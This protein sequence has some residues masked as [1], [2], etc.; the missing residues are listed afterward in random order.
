M[1][2]FECGATALGIILA[3]YGR[4]LPMSVLRE[5]C[6]VSTRGV[7]AAGML[8]AAR[9]YGLYAQGYRVATSSQLVGVA[10]PFISYWNVNHF[11]VVEGFTKTTI[12]LNDPAQGKRRVT[13][14][15]FDQEMSGVVLTFAPS[16]TFQRGGSPPTLWHTLFAH[17]REFGGMSI[18]V[19]M[20]ILCLAGAAL[21]VPLVV[22]H[23][24]DNGAN[25]A[26]WLLVGI[27]LL[28][29]VLVWGQQHLLA[30][31]EANVAWREAQ[32]YVRHLLQLPRS[33]LALRYASDLAYRMTHTATIA[34]LLS[35]Q[36]AAT[37][38]H[39]G[40]AS[41]FI[42]VLLG[43]DPLLGGIGAGAALVLALSIAW[44]EHALSQRHDYQQSVTEKHKLYTILE[45]GLYARESLRALGG[46]KALLRRLHDQHNRLL[47]ATQTLTSHTSHI[48][49]L[50]MIFTAIVPV[51]LLGMGVWRIQEGGGELTPGELGAIY[52]L[53]LG[54]VVPLRMLTS[55]TLELRAA[56]DATQRLDDVVQTPVVPSPIA[57]A[58]QAGNS[59]LLLALHKITVG[60]S[61]HD[62]PLLTNI[63]LEVAQG[64]IIALVG[65]SGSG[66][67]TLAALAAGLEEPWSGEVYRAAGVV[68][69]E[70]NAILFD[71]TIRDNLTLWDTTIATDVIIAA[72]QDACI[73]EIILALPQGYDTVISNNGVGMVSGGERQRLI[74]ARAF[75][76]NPTLLL[77]DE[78]ISAIDDTTCQH[79]IANIRCRQCAALVISHNTA[80]TRL[81]D[82]TIVLPT[83]SLAPPPVQTTI[84]FPSPTPLPTC[85]S[86]P[87]QHTAPLAPP[88][89]LPPPPLTLGRVLRFSLH[90]TIPH[91][92]RI[93]S[94]TLTIG[95][96]LLA[97]PLAIP[98]LID[99]PLGQPPS[100]WVVLL[101]SGMALAAVVAQGIHH[102][103]RQH[104]EQ[105]S[106]S[107]L[108]LALW[109]R[110]FAI[111]VVVL[112]RFSP[113]D[114]ITHLYAFT[115][116]YQ[117]VIHA[118]IQLGQMGIL[119]GL[120][121]GALLLLSP[122][123]GKAVL[124]F[125]FIWGVMTILLA[126]PLVLAEEQVATSERQEQH[127]LLQYLAGHAT[128]RTGNAEDRAYNQW[129]VSYQSKTTQLAQYQ[130]Y[131]ATQ[132]LM[133][134]LFHPLLFAV[135]LTAVGF[136]TPAL[137]I[138]YQLAIVSLLAQT[139]AALT[140]MS[141]LISTCFAI[142]P[143]FERVH[144]LLIAPLD[145]TD[146]LLTPHLVRGEIRLVGVSYQY[147]S[148]SNNGHARQATGLTV[149]DNLSLTIQPG[150]CVALMGSSGSGKT[151]LL[152]L[153]LGFFKPQ[154]GTIF[155]DGQELEQLDPQA[156]RQHMGV[157]LQDQHILPGNI[158]FNLVGE[159]DIPLSQIAQAIAVVGLDTWLC[160]LPMGVK[161]PLT[162]GG[163]TLS[164]GQKQQ[165]FLARALAAQPKIVLLDETFKSLDK[166]ICQR[167]LAY[168]RENQATCVFIT[169]NPHL[170]ALADRVLVLEQG[171]C[172]TVAHM[173]GFPQQETTL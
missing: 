115:Q 92:V 172:H 66:K 157:V 32:H 49:R 79:I 68:L 108:L 4:W 18:V 35:G 167:I 125:V 164:G 162:E 72:T 16:S 142:V 5:A 31:I 153:L 24:L 166:P 55:L 70:Q 150:E 9:H 19:G 112:N 30:Q 26:P 97:L 76:L 143:A 22:Q 121:L 103:A 124:V 168:I 42:I 46:E 20:L 160:Q 130:R 78:A 36:F 58:N 102:R 173:G 119:V 54:L 87:E 61:R 57:S 145:R 84:Q 60:Y 154:Q 101:L 94:T 56:N 140:P 171:V 165:V 111:P 67:S 75:V 144:S 52:L 51:C 45:D 71:G 120:P 126:R 6:G 53:T 109:Q 69:V 21:A 27:A 128:I 100:F 74:L 29:G 28:S 161:T 33:F 40:M 113:N 85:A 63:N 170:A 139:H 134:I 13:Y 8:K 2:A 122:P 3:Y 136:S 1:S 104:I 64:Q 73:H 107:R 48:L 132:E 83:L 137:S 7:T 110:V 152:R 149:L 15:T 131:Y 59:P 114:L 34:M 91:L 93:I 82:E 81:C 86:P 156:I 39:M 43:Y 123:V 105:T 129:V 146:T 138:G 10:L 148:D 117:A 25:G 98:R 133:I 141:S 118:G 37:L 62:P 88:A 12:L 116:A 127:R 17:L 14:A 151:T 163:I 96:A 44:L 80:I 77:L 38:L 169:H 90:G 95:L 65:K 89:P 135:G 11:V 23:M 147:D 47:Q 99:S 155:Y 106:G 41:V 158:W 159:R 50:P